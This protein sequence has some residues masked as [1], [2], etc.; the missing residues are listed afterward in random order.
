MKGQLKIGRE[1]LLDAEDIAELAGFHLRPGKIVTLIG[2]DNRT[3]RARITHLD[4][5][6]A[7]AFVFEGMPSAESSLEL[8][9]LQ[10]LPA[11][12]RME[13]IIEKSTELGVDV[14]VPFHSERSITLDE[15]DRSQAKSHTWQRRAVRAADQCRRARVPLIAPFCELSEAIEWVRDEKIKLMLWEKERSAGLKETLKAE[16]DIRSVAFLVGPEGGLSGAEVSLL[17][18]KGFVAVSLGGRI[19]R[20]ETAAIAGVS[21]IQYELGDLGAI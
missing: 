4:K 10:A 9:L 6:K 16:S 15:R 17:E 12:E 19:L 7:R 2:P 13:L 21:I 11:R 18:G 3:F 5:G 8:I 14:I 20:T 1:V